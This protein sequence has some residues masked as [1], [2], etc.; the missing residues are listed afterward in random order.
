MEPVYVAHE[1]FAFILEERGNLD[2][3]FYKFAYKPNRVSCSELDTELINLF[4][5][6]STRTNSKIDSKR[7]AMYDVAHA[8]TGFYVGAG[9]PKGPTV[10]SEWLLT[11]VDMFR[12]VARYIYTLL[13]ENDAPIGAIGQE[14]R[15]TTDAISH[16]FKPVLDSDA[17]VT[18]R[19][20]RTGFTPETYRDD[21]Y[22]PKTDDIFA[23]EKISQNLADGMERLIT[24]L[25]PEN[26]QTLAPRDLTMI[27]RFGILAFFLFAI[28]RANELSNQSRDVFFPLFLNYTGTTTSEAAALSNECLSRAENELI[29]AMEKGVTSALHESDANAY[30]QFAQSDN[31]E[32]LEVMLNSGPFG[33]DDDNEDL[34]NHKRTLIKNMYSTSDKSSNLECLAYAISKTIHMKTFDYYVPEKSL[35]DLGKYSGFVQPWKGVKRP[36]LYFAF[37]RPLLEAVVLSVL[38]TEGSR[39]LTLPDLCDRLRKRYGILV[40]GADEL[41]LQDHLGAWNISYSDVGVGPLSQ[42]GQ[43]Y[44]AVESELESLGLATKYADRVTIVSTNEY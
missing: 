15:R 11:E 30:Q 43:N 38:P 29:R 2:E 28:N 21:E 24:H 14:L 32:I 31:Q 23:S 25:K 13:V 3:E 10:T 42:L 5:P 35:I 16:I 22:G 37:D 44:D 27:V 34:I 18:L 12:E 36:Q 7:R 39:R 41:A 6:E 17:S 26:G 19:D 8:D 40:S 20:S 1:L 4:E 33:I 9:F